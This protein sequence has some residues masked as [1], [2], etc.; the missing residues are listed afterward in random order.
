MYQEQRIVTYCGNNNADNMFEDLIPA[1]YYLN[2][3]GTGL[4]ILHKI[5][6]L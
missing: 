5:Y 4:V 2:G 3:F 1:E 6:V